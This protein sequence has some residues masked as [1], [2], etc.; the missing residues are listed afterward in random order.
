MCNRR[1]KNITT[2]FAFFFF[3][4]MFKIR[5]YETKLYLALFV[6]VSLVK[7][8]PNFGFGFYSIPV[9]INS[10]WHSIH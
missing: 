7:L 6:P 10:V 9:A 4:L 8:F 2:P 3:F 1:R 5:F